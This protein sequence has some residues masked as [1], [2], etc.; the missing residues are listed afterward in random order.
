M[1]FSDEG[2][3]ISTMT[4]MVK[5]VAQKPIETATPVFYNPKSVRQSEF[6]AASAQGVSLESAVEIHTDDWNGQ[7]LFEDA[8]GFRYK[9][10]RS[11]VT[12]KNIVELTLQTEG[13]R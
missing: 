7:R 8:A 13:A 6:Y 11:Y 2:K 1:Y 10:F 3:L 4:P 9:V 12:E 5:G